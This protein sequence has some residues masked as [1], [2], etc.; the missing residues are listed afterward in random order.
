MSVEAEVTIH[1]QD[2][3]KLVDSDVRQRDFHGGVEIRW[4]ELHEGDFKVL[5]M[6]PVI[7]MTTS[8][9][10]GRVSRDDGTKASKEA[11]EGGYGRNCFCTT[12]P[13]TWCED[14]ATDLLE[15]SG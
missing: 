3:L 2:V 6:C 14:I 9:R 4:C 10:G 8:R 11:D 1:C 12:A 15:V 13:G 7:S 5:V